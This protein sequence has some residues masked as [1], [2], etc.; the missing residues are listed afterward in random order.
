VRVPFGREL[1]DLFKSDR[2][3]WL[4]MGGCGFATA[5]VVVTT[6][7]RGIHT[8]QLAFALSGLLISILIV[9]SF[10]VGAILALALA[11]KDVVVR[12]ITRGEPVSPLL[13]IYFGMRRRSLLVWF[14]TAIIATLVITIVIG[15]VAP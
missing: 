9:T 12:R 10:G 15:V 1:D 13:R 6:V 14:V 3:I 2:A 8:G 11:L 7:L 5:F 4:K